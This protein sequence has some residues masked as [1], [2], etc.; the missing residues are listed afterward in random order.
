MYS[1]LDMAIFAAP[2]PVM[3]LLLWFSRRA[4]VPVWIIGLG[5]GVG[6]FGVYVYGA[7]AYIEWVIYNRWW[8]FALATAC[9]AGIWATLR[10]ARAELWTHLRIWI[11]LGM[12]W[13][14]SAPALA[15]ETA[16]SAPWIAIHKEVPELSGMGYPRPVTPQVILKLKESLN[17]PDPWV[18]LGAAE[19]FLNREHVA[20]PE[21][22]AV[23]A[24]DK[25]S[26][27][28]WVA[29][30]ATQIFSS[31][32]TATNRELVSRLAKSAQN[33]PDIR[34]QQAAFDVLARMGD[35]KGNGIGDSTYAQ[36]GAPMDANSGRR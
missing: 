1:P 24:V 17:N 2:L 33:H 19:F 11:T 34:V 8:P 32:Y 21:I 6:V 14:L 7:Y 20:Y 3:L 23:L 29:L 9:G 12:A 30:R 10:E 5:T 28:R 25:K 18:R 26:S 13:I 27:Q 31:F 22:F 36:P 35:N 4:D 16:W 15:R